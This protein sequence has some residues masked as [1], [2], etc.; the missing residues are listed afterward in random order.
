MMAAPVMALL[1]EVVE[2]E[3]RAAAGHAGG[4]RVGEPIRV[5]LVRVANATGLGV[6]DDYVSRLRFNGK[7]VGENGESFRQSSSPTRATTRRRTPRPRASPP[8]SRATGR[9]W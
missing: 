4:L 7:S 1:E 6:A 5:A 3:L 8:R 9:T 2:P